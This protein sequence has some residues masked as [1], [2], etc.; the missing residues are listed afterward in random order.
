MLEEL[1]AQERQQ[2]GLRAK[3]SQCL[4][5]R[6]VTLFAPFLDEK[7]EAQDAWVAQPVRRLQVVIPGSWD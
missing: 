5:M 6:Q 7:T 1:S 3:R 2:G 4:P